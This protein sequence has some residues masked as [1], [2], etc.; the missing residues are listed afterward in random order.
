MPKVLVLQAKRFQ[1]LTAILYCILSFRFQTAVNHKIMNIK[2][3]KRVR[4]CIEDVFQKARPRYRRPKMFTHL[5][6][7]YGT[8]GH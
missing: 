3:D 8:E 2:D 6:S 4:G 7:Y 1:D 5:I